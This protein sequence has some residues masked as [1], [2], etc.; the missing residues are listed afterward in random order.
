MN[1]TVLSLVATALALFSSAVA[2]AGW[3]RA[4]LRLHALSGNNDAERPV[5]WRTLIAPFA[6]LLKPTG[7]DRDELII[8]LTQAGRGGVAGIA[9]FTQEKAVGLLVGPLLGLGAM[10]LFEETLGKMLCVLIGVAAGVI[11]P[12]R[13]L[14]GQIHERKTEIASALPSAVD[15]LMTTVDAGLSIEQAI[16]RTA[17][18]LSRSAPALAA[19][20]S[21]TGS[22]CEAGV[23]LGEAL[24]RLAR[25]VEVEDVSALC[26]VLS[27]A[28]ALGAPVV[29]TLAEYSDNARKLRIANLEEQAGKLVTKLTMPLAIFLLPS[30][31]IVML[32]PAFLQLFEVLASS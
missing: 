7:K 30:A 32:G 24:Q 25:R 9:R 8:Q 17:K 31:I 21:I 6:A 16:S 18:E 28:H 27:Q 10:T 13:R 1:V 4:R 2:L 19:E 11:L 20:L 12:R 29:K 15:L 26:G 14:E 5:I 22:E 23:G 3:Q